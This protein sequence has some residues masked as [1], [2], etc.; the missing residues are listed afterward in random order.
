VT[1]QNIH[2]RQTSMPAGG[3]R[4]RNPSKGATTDP[5]LRPCGHC[6]G[7]IYSTLFR[8]IWLAVCL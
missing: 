4:S 1:T 7:R 3:I 6:V 2:K 8:Y 5:R